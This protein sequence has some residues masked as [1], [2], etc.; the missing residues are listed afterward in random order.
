MLFGKLRSLAKCDFMLC[1]V[2]SVAN[3]AETEQLLSIDG[4]PSHPAVG[5]LQSFVIVRGSIPVL[6]TQLPNMK[7][8]PTTVIGPASVSGLVSGHRIRAFSVSFCV[9]LGAE[10]D[11]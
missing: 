6:W 9:S 5:T 2:G 1:P 11:A 10:A 7:Y 8:K 4:P 3:Y